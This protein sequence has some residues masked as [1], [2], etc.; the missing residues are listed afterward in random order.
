MEDNPQQEGSPE[1]TERALACVHS[2]GI[3]RH[4]WNYQVSGWKRKGS[5]T[6]ELVSAHS[7]GQREALSWL[8]TTPHFL[9]D[10]LHDGAEG[11]AASPS[12]LWKGLLILSRASLLPVPVSSAPPQAKVSKSKEDLQQQ[13]HVARS[14]SHDMA[15][16]CS[17]NA[18]SGRSPLSS[19][20][21]EQVPAFTSSQEQS[22]QMMVT[23]AQW[24]CS[25]SD[26]GTS[27]INQE[28]T[29]LLITKL[30]NVRRKL[31]PLL[32][33]SKLNINHNCFEHKNVHLQI[34][35]MSV[36]I[37]AE[38]KLYSFSII[39]LNKNTQK[40]GQWCTEATQHR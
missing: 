26:V 20:D 4:Q 28:K 31:I 12:D 40:N 25:H 8:T 19:G 21:V 29:V 34:F 13:A 23:S 9:S 24:D 11:L 7:C 5:M 6:P 3:T 35:S 33:V 22:F 30:S 10:C 2:T 37:R 38:L 27:G 36:K 16:L 1:H 39:S 14:W 15:V 32:D 17:L 18:T